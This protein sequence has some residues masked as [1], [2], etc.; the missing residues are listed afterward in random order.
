MG[1]T[2]RAVDHGRRR[3]IGLRGLGSLLRRRE[4]YVIVAERLHADHTTVPILAKVKTG[5]GRYWGLHPGRKAGWRHPSSGDRLDG[6]VQLARNSAS[7]Q[8]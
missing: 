7:G 3:R 4:A 6:L 1:R 5:T 8:P 2:E